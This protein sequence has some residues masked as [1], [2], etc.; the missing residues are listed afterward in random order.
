MKPSIVRL[1]SLVWGL[2]LLCTVSGTSAQLQSEATTRH[3]DAPAVVA[4]HFMVAAAHPLAVEAGYEILKRGGSAMDAAIAVQM[5]LGL[6]EPQASGIGG[7][8]FV[9]YLGEKSRGLHSYHGPGAPPAAG[10]ADRV[11][12]AP[13]TP[14]A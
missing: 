5:A 13:G 12:K 7:G 14:V 11:P 9:L 4:T 1:G 10:R 8:A 6:A 2:C 3:V